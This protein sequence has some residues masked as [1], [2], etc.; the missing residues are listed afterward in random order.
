[1]WRCARS[2][3]IHPTIQQRQICYDG[4]PLAALNWRSL[5][6]QFGVVLQ[7]PFLFSGSIRQNITV[8]HP[9]LA[10]ESVKAAAQLAA[11]HDQIMQLPMAYETRIAEGGTGL[12]GGQRQR[13]AIARALA[14]RPAVLLLDEATSHLDGVTESVVEQNLSQLS[15]TRIVIAHRLSTV[16]NADQIFVLDQGTIVERGTHEQLLKQQGH[17]AALVSTRVRGSEAAMRG[18]SGFFQ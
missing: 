15:C 12:S 14:E 6:S 5:R 1:M 9:S 18:R 8:N 11:I 13:L 17:Y 3:L 16:R 7:E 10:F 2:C 4:I